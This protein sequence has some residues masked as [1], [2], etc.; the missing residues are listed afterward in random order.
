MRELSSSLPQVIRSSPAKVRAETK[1]LF[2]NFVRTFSNP[3]RITVYGRAKPE[4]EY[5]DFTRSKEF[6]EKF[7]TQ[8][9][10]RPKV[11]IK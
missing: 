1:F 4:G 7:L 11:R 10:S 5:N 6:L 3:Q 9:T 2:S 8:R